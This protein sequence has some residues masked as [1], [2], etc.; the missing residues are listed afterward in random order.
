M[1]VKIRVFVA[2]KA[3][4]TCRV[5]GALCIATMS[6]RSHAATSVRRWRE[7]RRPVGGRPAWAG[8]ESQLIHRDHPHDGE[9]QSHQVVDAFFPDVGIATLQLMERLGVEIIY[10]LDQTCCGQ[11]MANSGSQKDAAQGL[12]SHPVQLVSVR[13]VTCR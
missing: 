7:Y 8:G 2:K 10:P 9:A 5:G 13:R 4:P 12:D 3:L 6:A 1:H 11:M